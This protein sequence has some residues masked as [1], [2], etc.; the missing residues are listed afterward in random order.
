MAKQTKDR[1]VI[2]Y[3]AE[4]HIKQAIDEWS[5]LLG[6]NSRNEFMDHLII[7]G[8]MAHELAAEKPLDAESFASALYT[9]GARFIEGGYRGALVETV[10][11]FKAW[12]QVKAREMTRPLQPGRVLVIPKSPERELRTG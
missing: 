7:V 3:R 5:K 6:F 8:L 1:S 12:Q 9:I 10:E 11:G 2:T 4:D